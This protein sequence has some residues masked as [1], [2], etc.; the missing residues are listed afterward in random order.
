MKLTEKEK[1]LLEAFGH[2]DY[3]EYNDQHWMWDIKDL[4]GLTGKSFSGVCA[5]LHEKGLIDSDTE[6]YRGD[7]GMKIADTYT[8]WLTKS[9]S[10]VYKEM[11]NL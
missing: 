6:G 10:N 7:V 11:S 3:G 9:G 5:S 2:S 8:I 4:S 1:Q